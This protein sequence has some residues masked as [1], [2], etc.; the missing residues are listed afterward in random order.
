MKGAKTWVVE[1]FESAK[2]SHTESGMEILG[3]IK[4]PFLLA[5]FNIH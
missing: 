5:I 2:Y 1:V 3:G 4:L